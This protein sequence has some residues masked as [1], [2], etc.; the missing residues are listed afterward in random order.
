MLKLTIT[1]FI[2]YDINFPKSLAV[3]MSLQQ[4]GTL[5]P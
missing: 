2:D 1:S 4:T 3:E 5:A